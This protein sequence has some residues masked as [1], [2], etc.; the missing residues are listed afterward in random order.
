MSKRPISPL[1]TNTLHAYT[2][3]SK[4]QWVGLCP[5]HML[6]WKAVCHVSWHGIPTC[7]SKMQWLVL[8]TSSFATLEGSRT[9]WWYLPLEAEALASFRME[10]KTLRARLHPLFS[11]TATYKVCFKGCFF[12]RMSFSEG[13][14]IVV[15]HLHP[16][17]LQGQACYVQEDVC[18]EAAALWVSRMF[19]PW[20]FRHMGFMLM[21]FRKACDRRWA[22]RCFTLIRQHAPPMTRTR[23]RSVRRQNGGD[24][25]LFSEKIDSET[26]GST[27][28]T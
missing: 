13:A 26:I 24:K 11:K 22:S 17:L 12:L 19:V 20:K 21:C 4:M 3:Y 15:W 1:L 2:C 10:P 25:S 28:T 7:Y 8:H 27:Q 9:C 5:F 6:P 16:C 18:L 23:S 14:W